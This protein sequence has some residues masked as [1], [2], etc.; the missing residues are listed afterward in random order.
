MC[1]GL[2]GRILSVEEGSGPGGGRTGQVEVAGIVRQI[3]LA[4]LRGP[5]LPGEHVLIHSGIAL[6]RMPADQAREAMSIAAIS[7]FPP[8]GVLGEGVAQDQGPPG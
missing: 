6:E 8:P 5:V 1:L 7:L 4:L 3:D 2:P